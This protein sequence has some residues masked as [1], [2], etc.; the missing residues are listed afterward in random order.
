VQRY[1]KVVSHVGYTVKWGKKEKERDITKSK[2]FLLKRGMS[3]RVV[4]GALHELDTEITGVLYLS[5]PL[6]RSTPR[7]D[8]C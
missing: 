8:K 6:T 1:K 2:S 4:Y 3:Y 7:N 5:G